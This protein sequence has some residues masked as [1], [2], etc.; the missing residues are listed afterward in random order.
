MAGFKLGARPVLNAGKLGLYLTH[1][2]GRL[3]L[4]RLGFRA[5]VGRLNQ[6]KDFDAFCVEEAL[7]ETRKRRLLVATDGEVTWMETP[8][9]YR[10]RPAALRVLVP[11]RGNGA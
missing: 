5:L 7:I 1:R 3:G 10:T 11:R 2:T 6:A 4:F 8:L 9:Y